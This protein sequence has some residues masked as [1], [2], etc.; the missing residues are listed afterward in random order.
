MDEDNEDLVLIQSMVNDWIEGQECCNFKKR[1]RL[2]DATI[3][4]G[5][6]DLTDSFGTT[7]FRVETGGIFERPHPKAGTFKSSSIFD[8][9][10]ASVLKHLPTC[11]TPLFLE[12][13]GISVDEQGDDFEK[14]RCW[15][16]QSI[17]E[18]NRHTLQDLVLIHRDAMNKTNDSHVFDLNDDELENVIGSMTSGKQV[19]EL[20]SRLGIKL[21]KE[22]SPLLKLQEWTNKCNGDERRETLRKALHAMDLSGC[23]V[24]HLPAKHVDQAEL[25]RLAWTLFS[26]DVWPLA[27]LLDIDINKGK[28][29]GEPQ[30][31]GTVHLLNQLLKKSKGLDEHRRL[32]FC[33]AII[34]LGYLD[35]AR[36][37]Y[38]GYD[39]SLSELCNM[40]S[41]LSEVELVKFVDHLGLE[42]DVL[43]ICQGTTGAYDNLRLMKV[44]RNQLRLQPLHF[45][46]ELAVGLRAVGRT[47]IA[48]KILAGRHHTNEVGS[49][50][51]ESICNSLENDQMKRLR[52]HLR[53]KTQDD[54]SPTTV[55]AAL[56]TEWAR[57]WLEEFGN[58]SVMKLFKDKIK[59]PEN[60]SDNE[61]EV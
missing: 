53:L 21:D 35:V 2:D 17:N 50:V 16:D 42:K 18:S 61:S 19:E 7:S 41:G 46:F 12:K 32:D 14:L 13:L 39:A 40:T 37:G 55:T 25:V 38:F 60:T 33:V 24:D 15:R 59:C 34:N 8:D 6:H 20:T 22:Q 49:S 52:E 5:R 11:A 51:V 4:I 9:D 56:V 3:K 58:I 43:S 1:C 45:R 54:Q 30:M 28:T 23:I 48:S 36:S 10:L 57:N 27:T 26:I 47:E 29:V 31:R 44:W